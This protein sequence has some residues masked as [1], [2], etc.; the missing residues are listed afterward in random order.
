[1]EFSRKTEF[2]DRRRVRN[3]PG[4]ME[5]IRSMGAEQK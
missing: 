5:E 1:V 3:F 4:N 2:W